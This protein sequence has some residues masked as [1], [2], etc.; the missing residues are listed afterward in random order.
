MV[1]LVL[2]VLV[3]AVLVLVAPVVHLVQGLATDSRRVENLVELV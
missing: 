1:V 3:L 2:A